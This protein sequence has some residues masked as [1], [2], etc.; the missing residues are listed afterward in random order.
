MIA[1][2]PPFVRESAIET[3]YAI[4][5]EDAAPLPHRDDLTPE[6][7]HVIRHCLEREP[8]ARF[9]SARDLAFILGFTLR[10]PQRAEPARSPRR[11][12]E[13]IFALF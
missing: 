11:Q 5:R 3:L 1:G 2:R 6:L 9:Q 10:S 7:E 8:P 12:L 13:S 4:L